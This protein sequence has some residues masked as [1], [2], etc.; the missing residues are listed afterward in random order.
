MSIKNYCEV[1]LGWHINDANTDQNRNYSPIMKHQS[2]RISG[3][4]MHSTI[5][6]PWTDGRFIT[7]YRVGRLYK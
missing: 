6:I 7:M 3:E 1:K 2:P 5:V 4:Y